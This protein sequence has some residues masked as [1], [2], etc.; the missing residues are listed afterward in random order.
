MT[1]TAVTAVSK[2]TQTSAPFHK[3]PAELWVKIATYAGQEIVRCSSL[4]KQTKAA[5]N[6]LSST[7]WYEH[8]ILRFGPPKP[9]ENW[10]ERFIESGHN[11]QMGMRAKPPSIRDRGYITGCVLEEDELVVAKYGEHGKFAS[12]VTWSDLGKRETE[13]RDFDSRIYSVSYQRGVFAAVAETNDGNRLNI[14]RRGRQN[15]VR[16]LPFTGEWAPKENIC[17]LIG[18]NR[19]LLSGFGPYQGTGLSLV[20]LETGNTILPFGH[21]NI[22][23]LGAMRARFM[24][25]HTVLATHPYA[26]ASAIHKLYVWDIRLDFNRAPA[27]TYMLNESYCPNVIL[28]SQGQI[29]T[30]TTNDPFGTGQTHLSLRD[31]R[32]QRC[33]KIVKPKGDASIS[34]LTTMG[35]VIFSGS[36][37][38]VLRCWDSQLK[39]MDKWVLPGSQK[40]MVPCIT[41]SSSICVFLTQ[42]VSANAT[43]RY[44]N[45][46]HPTVLWHATALPFERINA[47]AATN[48]K[49]HAKK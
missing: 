8:H 40:M 25:A 49:P 18:H 47:N 3:F 24:D 20:D 4:N 7:L 14:W 33:A 45:L 36:N 19:I 42:E 38:G 15:S 34:G 23:I 31:T 32:T 6:A 26:S 48:V 41:A 13:T 5:F 30:T 28:T 43:K 9:S 29:C 27:Q 46:L 37:N 2:P 1:A 22:D 16:T 44:W 39:L 21:H 11:L 35:G 12:K 10:Q 17:C